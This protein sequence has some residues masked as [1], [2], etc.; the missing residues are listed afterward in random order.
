[1][2]VPIW[3]LANGLV[4]IPVTPWSKKGGVIAHHEVSQNTRIL[5]DDE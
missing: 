2:L 1:V 4:W 3:L 5:A